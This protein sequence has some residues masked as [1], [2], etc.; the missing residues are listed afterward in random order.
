MAKKIVNLRKTNFECYK[1][2]IEK[3]LAHS[4]PYKPENEAQL[5]ERTNIFTDSCAS[6]KRLKRVARKKNFRTA[7]RCMREKYDKL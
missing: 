6:G 1:K 3:G 7:P 5:E 2:L 4:P